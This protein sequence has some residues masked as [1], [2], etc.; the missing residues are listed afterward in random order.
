MRR[1]VNPLRAADSRFH[2]T[3]SIDRSACG[4]AFHSSRS[5]A[6]RSPLAFQCVASAA[7]C[8]ASSTIRSLTPRASERACSRA[9]LTSSRRASTAPVSASSR[10]RSPSRSPSALASA[11]DLS[12]RCTVACAWAGAISVVV[13]R[14][15]I[16]VT[17]V[18]SDSN[19]RRK[20]ASASSGLPAAHEPITRS[21]SAVRT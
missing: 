16:S 4:A 14:C 11:T 2:S 19:L 7:M 1:L 12:S 6:I 13:M 10:V 15:S 9:A 18:S 3:A 8:S 5:S 17:S 21:P 20:N